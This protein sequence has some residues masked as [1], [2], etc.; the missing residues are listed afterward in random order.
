MNLYNIIFI[1][2]CKCIINIFIVH[3]YFFVALFKSEKKMQNISRK[4]CWNSWRNYLISYKWMRFIIIFLSLL[5]M[6]LYFNANYCINKI[7]RQLLMDDD[8]Y[9]PLIEY[10]ELVYFIHYNDE[11]KKFDLRV[12]AKKIFNIE[13]IISPIESKLKD[14]IHKNDMNELKF[15]TRNGIVFTK[16]DALK[17][18]V[19]HV[20]DISPIQIELECPSKIADTVDG[21]SLIFKI[22]MPGLNDY[23][24]YRSDTFIVDNVQD[25]GG[26]NLGEIFD[27]YDI[28]TILNEY[29]LNGEFKVNLH[30]QIRTTI[31]FPKEYLNLKWKFIQKNNVFLN[32]GN[33]KLKYSI[34]W[35]NDD[36]RNGQYLMMDW[37]HINSYQD[38]Y[39][40]YPFY[41]LY[42]IH[43]HTS[44]K[45]VDMW[46]LT[47]EKTNWRTY[48]EI[49][50]KTGE[51]MLNIMIDLNDITKVDDMKKA[52]QWLKG[53]QLVLQNNSV[54][55]WI[56]IPSTWEQTLNERNQGCIK[57]E[58]RVYHEVGRRPVTLLLTG[59]DGGQQLISVAETDTIGHLM[60]LIGQK[61]NKV[62]AALIDGETALTDKRQQSKIFR[63]N[64]GDPKEIKVIFKH[65]DI[66]E[67]Y[68]FMGET[69]YLRI[70][71]NV[72]DTL[73]DLEAEIRRYGDYRLCG[74]YTNEVKITRIIQFDPDSVIITP[75]V[76]G[77][78]LNVVIQFND[79]T[80]PI[81]DQGFDVKKYTLLALS[82]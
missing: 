31:K 32:R 15:K 70:L 2:I 13:D 17:K 26:L 24:P 36:H 33:Y 41:D 40:Q 42:P 61:E 55:D 20:D 46:G 12:D 59:L 79:K 66:A 72:A 44:F 14:I 34:L 30:Y 49:V 80:K 7:E 57:P 58:Y 78:T 39:G 76:R 53:L 52:V 29:Q 8:V 56:K 71:V 23:H 65:E 54:F 50:S 37:Q 68:L 22:S 3:K 43:V 18:I 60:A 28:D 11:I 69:S 6:I 74:V 64:N 73:E 4:K 51:T 16:K 62:V 9:T 21:W 38:F 47:F 1:N 81:I 82:Q 35:R 67:V 77:Q 10:K 45:S 27:N 48:D 75:R 5:C 63:S 19:G 25:F